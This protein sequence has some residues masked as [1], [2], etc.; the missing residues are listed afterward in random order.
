M[1]AVLDSPAVVMM[2]SLNFMPPNLPLF[3]ALQETKLQ[4]LNPSKRK[5]FLP[6]R[7]AICETVDSIGASG[8]ILTAWDSKTCSLASTLKCDY[9]LTTA[10]NFLADE[11]ML[12]LTNI[13]APAR[14]EDRPLFF[15]ELTNVASTITGPWILIGDFNLIR[16]AED[17][18]SHSFDASEAN[19]FNDL[20]NNLGLIEIPLVVVISRGATKKKHQLLSG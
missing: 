16:S 13:Y 20:I 8:G 15:T 5:T 19:H 18:N 7:L 1:S 10:L 6:N 9:S 12:T 17:K 3:A 4:V 11:S 2:F 14:R